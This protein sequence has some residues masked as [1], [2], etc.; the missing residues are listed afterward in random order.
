M[1]GDEERAPAVHRHG[2]KKGLY[3]YPW[4]CTRR[5]VRGCACSLDGDGSALEETPCSIALNASALPS[6]GVAAAQ[7]RVRELLLA[8]GAP[9][10]RPPAVPGARRRMPFEA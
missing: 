5:D 9:V 8:V 1:H 6:A 4:R 3:D 10:P 7:S 2:V